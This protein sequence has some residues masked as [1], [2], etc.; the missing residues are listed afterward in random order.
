ME[1]ETSENGFVHKDITGK[2]LKSAFEVHNILGCGFKE[3]IYQ[4]ALAQEFFE[5][6]IQYEQENEIAICYK[7]KSAPIGY[8][9]AD[10]II[11][12]LVLIEIKAKSEL[13][14]VDFVQTLNYI[15]VYNLKVGLLINFGETSLKYKRLANNRKKRA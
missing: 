11:E 12:G 2:I 5:S 1:N 8:L 4:R 13:E 6:G 15:R 10:F 14:P 3:I 7:N 9:K